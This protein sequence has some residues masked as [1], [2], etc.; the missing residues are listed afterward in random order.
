M[1]H[2]QTNYNIL[3]LCNDDPAVDVRLTETGIQQAESAAFELAEVPLNSIY[4]SQ[5]PRTRQTAEIVNC[6]H[7]VPIKTSAYLNDIRSGFES[8]SVSEYFAVTGH[9]RYHITPPGG[10]SVQQFQQRALRFLDEIKSI[11]ENTILVVTHEE[12]MRVF[13]AYF[14]NLGPEEM[15]RLNFGNCEFLEFTT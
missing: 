5:L 4:V 9:D 14:N 1:R 10:E 2:G 7:N 13:Y 12:T 11:E 3:G 15:L 6:H 8:R